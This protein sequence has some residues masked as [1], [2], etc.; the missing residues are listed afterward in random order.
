MSDPHIDI[1]DFD[2]SYSND[3]YEPDEPVIEFEAIDEDRHTKGYNFW[4]WQR[5]PEMFRDFSDKFGAASQQNTDEFIPE[6]ARR[7]FRNSQREFLLGWR[8]IIDQ[9]LERLDAREQFDLARAAA[10]NESSAKVKV[11]VE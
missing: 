2:S 3:D 8:I 4:G 11:T 5:L 6:E 10:G 9:Q 1:E 7:R